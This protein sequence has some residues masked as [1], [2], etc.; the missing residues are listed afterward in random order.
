MPAAAAGIVA[1][2]VVKMA[3]VVV[4]QDPDDQH[5]SEGVNRHE[6]GVDRPFFLDDAAV[7]NGQPG[8]ALQTDEGCGGQLPSVISGI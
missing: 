2:P 8:D 3:E 4:E 1:W 5:R 6:G 7:E